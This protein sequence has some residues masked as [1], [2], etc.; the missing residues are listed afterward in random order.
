MAD[1]GGRCDRRGA[2]GM[3]VTLLAPALLLRVDQSVAS[4]IRTRR[5]GLDKVGV[6]GRWAF[7]SLSSPPLVV[8]LWWRNRRHLR[9]VPSS[10]DGASSR[11][12]AL[13]QTRNEGRQL[14]LHCSDAPRLWK[15]A[16]WASHIPLSLS[17]S[18]RP[19]LQTLMKR[20]NIRSDLH[21]K[22]S[23]VSADLSRIIDKMYYDA[24][25]KPARLGNWEVGRTFPERPRH[26]RGPTRVIA[27]DRGHLLPGV[28]RT[29]ASPWGPLTQAIDP[30]P[31]ERQR[32]QTDQPRPFP[33]ESDDEQVS[34]LT[35]WDRVLVPHLMELGA[36]VSHLVELRA[37]VSHL[38]E[39]RALV[40]HLVELRALVSHLM[41]LRALVSHLEDVGE[42]EGGGLQITGEGLL[43][44]APR[45]SDAEDDPL[46]HQDPPQEADRTQGTITPASFRRPPKVSNPPSVR[47][48]RKSS[49]GGSHSSIASTPNPEKILKEAAHLPPDTVEDALLPRRPE[50]ELVELTGSR[51][52]AIRLVDHPAPTNCTK[53]V[54]IRP[55]TAPSPAPSTK[56]PLLPK[57]PKTAKI[58]RKVPEIEF[59]LKWDLKENIMEE[60]E[61]DEAIEVVSLKKTKS[62]DPPT[63]RSVSSVDSGVHIP[64]T[65]WNDGPD[66]GELASKLE[67]L[68]MNQESASSS[69][70]RPPEP[71]SGYGTPKSRDSRASLP[72][73]GSRA[74][75]GK[76]SVKM[77][78]KTGSAPS[79]SKNG[80]RRI[81]M[82]S[83]RLAQESPKSTPKSRIASS[84]VEKRSPKSS[85]ESSRSIETQGSRRKVKPPSPRVEDKGRSETQFRD[86]L[87]IMETM[88]S[89]FHTVPLRDTGRGNHTYRSTTAEKRQVVAATQ[90]E[91]PVAEAFVRS[92][93]DDSNG[94]QPTEAK[95]RHNHPG[96]LRSRNCLACE[97]RA[98]EEPPKKFQG[99]SDY[100]PA[101]KAGKVHQGSNVKK[102]KYMRQSERY[103]ARL[104]ARHEP[105]RYW[106]INTLSSPFCNRA[107]YGQDQYPDHMRLRTTYGMAHAPTPKPVHTSLIKKLYL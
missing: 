38:V 75:S 35:V 80:S 31:Q 3:A 99:P 104:R 42:G 11:P 71:E 100:K 78:V 81:S 5:H 88:D 61:E 22:H 36:L 6:V 82:D 84:G 1:Q 77:P 101:F 53:Y 14:I 48:S 86:P 28:P 49:V 32:R 79:D 70:Q 4:R 93:D 52:L 20:L 17:G 64:K 18:T 67:R 95:V 94:G 23:A 58:I 25:Y 63:P 98:M 96:H 56:P 15:R 73:V 89:V 92:S 60:E 10:G 74:S 59:A 12:C 50:E 26:R 51:A 37:L 76:S 30:N 66:T 68:E 54:V 21:L 55:N 83:Q 33:S 106:P 65:A 47:S 97:V 91:E 45:S 40:S 13:A 8:R 9:P 57:R 105:P 27:D 39:L 107:G 102:P 2:A 103:N 34:Q 24:G 16:L 41:E 62:R 46:Q 85:K 29:Q 72:S 90:T 7:C 43:S 44:G 19:P 69:R 87:A